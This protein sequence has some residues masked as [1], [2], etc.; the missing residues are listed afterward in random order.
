MT[1][2]GLS[3]R[4]RYKLL[5]QD[6]VLRIVA[7]SHLIVSTTKKKKKDLKEKKLFLSHRESSAGKDTC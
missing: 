1:L 7:A 2:A 5:K 6:L 4:S 3:N